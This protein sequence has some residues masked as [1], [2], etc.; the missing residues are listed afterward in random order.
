MSD[1][2][3]QFDQPSA[4]RGRIFSMVRCMK[5]SRPQRASSVWPMAVR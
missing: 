5:Y 3:K 4:K 1:T 2:I